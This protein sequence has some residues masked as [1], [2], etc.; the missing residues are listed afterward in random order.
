MMLSALTT[1]A[2]LSMACVRCMLRRRPAAALAA[3]KDGH[4]VMRPDNWLLSLSHVLLPP[5]AALAMRG[6]LPGSVL[7]Q[8]KTEEANLVYH[9][10]KT[11]QA[12]HH[13]KRRKPSAATAAGGMTG[14]LSST[15]RESE[16]GGEA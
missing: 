6:L 9:D 10:P 1:R 13:Q 5:A 7:G 8:I 16:T 2:V 12:T 14:T 15:T 3:C 4:H 11:A